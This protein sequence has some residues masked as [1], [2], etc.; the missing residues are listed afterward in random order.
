MLP[1]RCGPSLRCYK[2]CD[3]VPSTA[4]TP[5]TSL[6][7]PLR[8]LA[9]PDPSQSEEP[10]QETRAPWYQGRVRGS[11]RCVLSSPAATCRLQYVSKEQYYRC[12][13]AEAITDRTFTPPP[14]VIGS[15]NCSCHFFTPAFPSSHTTHPHIH[16]HS[17]PHPPTYMRT[18][19]HAHTHTCTH[20]HA[21]TY[22]HVHAH[23]YTHVHAHTYT[24]V[25][26]HTYTH[27]HAHTHTHVHA[28]THTH[29][30]LHTRTRTYIHAPTYTC[31]MPGSHRRVVLVHPEMLLD[32]RNQHEF[33]SLVKELAPPGEMTRS[34]TF[35]FEFRT[36][37]K[38][39][40]TYCGVQVWLA[41]SS[42]RWLPFGL[43]A[44]VHRRAGGPT[45][46]LP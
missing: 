30:H 29:T 33:T 43:Y 36:V 44:L 45:G 6:H 37:E 31:P 20:A 14:P 16:K 40:E 39:H 7:T 15:K 8:C 27:V 17:C 19:A 35:D 3:Q 46:C 28:P 21:P 4:H 23:T 12:T 34:K 9:I 26:A 32:S 13:H 41:A 10:G 2:G 42:H 25:H 1:A 11:D 38:A 5:R 24:H 18:H 22:T